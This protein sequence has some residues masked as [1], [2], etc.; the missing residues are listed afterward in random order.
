MIRTRA[1]ATAAGLLALSACG[2]RDADAGVVRLGVARVD[3]LGAVVTDQDG[4]TLYRFDRDTARP[5]VS[6]CAGDCAKSWPPMIVA[7]AGRV[8]LADVDRTLVGTVARADGSRQLTLAGWPL[9]RY[10]DDRRAGDSKGQ[11]VGG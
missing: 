3:Q 2:H 1:A 10:V 7:D 4:H 8:K 5:S 9:Y 6:N 11:G